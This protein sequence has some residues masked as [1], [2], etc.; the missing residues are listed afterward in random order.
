M[1]CVRAIYF[2]FEHLFCLSHDHLPLYSRIDFQLNSLVATDR[3]FVRFSVWP[4][5]GSCKRAL[6]RESR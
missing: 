5:L 6:C 2:A 3:S 4:C 1:Q